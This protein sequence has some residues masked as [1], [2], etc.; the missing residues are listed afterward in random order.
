[1]FL[2]IL[3]KFQEIPS[4]KKSHFIA[5]NIAHGKVLSENKLKHLTEVNLKK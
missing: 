4:I 1:M 3:F 2:H 5:P